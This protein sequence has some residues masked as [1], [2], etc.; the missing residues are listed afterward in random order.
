MKRSIILLAV[1]FVV[2]G[3]ITASA[4][5]LTGQLGLG[6]N[7]QLRSANLSAR[8]WKSR[9]IGWEGIFGFRIGE[10]GYKNVEM[11]GKILYV[12][13]EEENMN[14]YAT[15]G[16]GFSIFKGMEVLGV[17]PDT[18]FNLRMVGGLGVEFFFQGLPNLSFGAEV[19]M[20]Y[21]DIDFSSFG[22]EIDTIGVGIHYYFKSPL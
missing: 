10:A 11:G 18:E 20:G 13:R 8:Q 4:K 3:N 17:E 19:N 6:F 7:Q 2:W 5:D 22:I 21:S 9:K 12:I 1:I 16:I 15:G 14:V